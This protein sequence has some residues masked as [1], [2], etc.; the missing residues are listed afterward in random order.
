MNRGDQREGIFLDHQDHWCFI[1]ALSQACEKTR[2]QVCG[3][4]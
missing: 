2:W 4:P 3:L 1:R